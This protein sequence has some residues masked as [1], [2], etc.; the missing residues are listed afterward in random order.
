MKEKMKKLLFKLTQKYLLEV[1]T[2]IKPGDL[3]NKGENDAVFEAIG[4]Y[5]NDNLKPFIFFSDSQGYIYSAPPYECR[6]AKVVGR[7]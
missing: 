5:Y 4:I 3:I 7:V 6:R 2:D 1:N